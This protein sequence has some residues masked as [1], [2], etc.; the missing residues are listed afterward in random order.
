VLG[1]KPAP[2]FEAWLEGEQ[3]RQ[4]RIEADDPKRLPERLLSA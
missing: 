1:L 2:E 3:F 4:L